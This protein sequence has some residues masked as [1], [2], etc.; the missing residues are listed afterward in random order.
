MI[1]AVLLEQV[2]PL[3]ME[4]ALAVQ[5]EIVKRAREAEKLLHRQVERAQYE[6]DLAR[7]RL[8]AVDPALRHVAQTLEADWNDKLEHLQQ[9]QHDYETRRANSHHVLNAQQQA[10]IRRLAT[11]FPSIWAHPATSHQD[12]KRMA[13]LLIEDVT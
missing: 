5:Q 6:A 9:A 2:T 10:E 7:R 4:A 3:A 8:M 12:K 11:D 1:S 13:R